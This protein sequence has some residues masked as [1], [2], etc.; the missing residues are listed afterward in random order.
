MKKLFLLLLLC[1]PLN[2]YAES[3]YVN[4]NNIEMSYEE[5]NDLLNLGFNE[6]EIYN[7]SLEE[8]EYNYGL[9]AVPVSEDS[10]YY[11]TIVL[12]ETVED[13]NNLNE[14]AIVEVISEE[15]NENEYLN[16]DNLMGNISYFGNGVDTAPATVNIRN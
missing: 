8:Y 2:V 11:K 16:S 9:N 12:Y 10:K 5:Y 4:R 3:F 6:K 13:L 7:M 14:D 15:V 1:F